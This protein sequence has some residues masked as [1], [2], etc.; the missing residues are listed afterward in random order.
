VSGRQVT[1]RRTLAA[2]LT[3]VLLSPA[4]A[5]CGRDAQP[6]PS[7]PTAVP[8]EVPPEPPAPEPPAPEPP[9]PEPPA[10]EPPAP[11][12]PAPEPPAPEAPLGQVV[13]V[14]RV[15]DGDTIDTTAGRVRL[16]GIDTPERGECNFGPASFLLR[17]QISNYGN[18]VVLVSVPGRDRTDRYGRLLRYVD[19][20][21]GTDLG[22]TLI[23]AG[24]GVARYDSRDGYGRHP[25]QDDYVALDA[26]VPLVPCG[27]A[28]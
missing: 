18:T 6:A 24:L 8:S 9:A 15:I 27:A 20:P 4:I 26:S 3:G 25:R 1:T 2:L 14:T 10:P 21:D 5:G 19:A 28:N 13:T 16:I 11:E 22:R 23:A 7:S 17:S 12:P